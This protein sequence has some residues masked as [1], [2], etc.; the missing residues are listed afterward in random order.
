MVFDLREKITDKLKNLVKTPVSMG[1]KK[2]QVVAI[3]SNK[4]GVGKTTT[5]VNLAVAMSRQGI[6]TLL[7]DLDPQAHVS[8]CL[9][10]SPIRELTLTA[11][12][13]GHGRDLSEVAYPSGY[14]NLDIAGSEKSLLDLEPILSTKIGKEF[15]LGEALN[16][17]RTHYDLILMDCP[18]NLG[19]LTL[20]ALCAADHLLVPA[21][22]SVLAIEGV[23][24]ILRVVDTLHTRLGRTLSV[25]GVLLTRYDARASSLN[26]SM[27]TSLK[28][29]Y[30]DLLM[31]TRIPQASAL[32]R[33]HLKGKAVF[34]VAGTSKGAQAYIKLAHEITKRLYLPVHVIQEST[35]HQALPHL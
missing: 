25:L 21:D 27:E 8:A 34:D 20:N 2:A 29:L 26:A 22:L 5:A 10:T 23:G 4:G 18:P 19:T 1:S 24:D 16:G 31:H 35:A 13:S 15:I 11:L 7:V 14:A 9:R 32:N 12:L 30:G 28:Q 6:R 33:A 3:A 17:A